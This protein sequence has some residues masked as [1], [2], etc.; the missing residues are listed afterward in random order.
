MAR[1]VSKRDLAIISQLR[2]DSRMTLT[3]MSRNLRIPI[4]TLHE[5]LKWLRSSG[6][7]KLTVLTDFETLGFGTRV[8]IVIKVDRDDRAEVEEFL[9]HPRFNSLLRVNNGYTFMIDMIMDM[10]GIED[11]LEDLETRFRIRKRMVFY[12]LGEVKR[13]AFLADPSTA[14]VLLNGGDG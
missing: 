6:M 4:S 1:T 13:E 8:L 7:L 12:V 2:S 5:R 10:R 14:A 9:K 11:F 3:K